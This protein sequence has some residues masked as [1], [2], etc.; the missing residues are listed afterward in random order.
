MKLAIVARGPRLDS[1]VE[2]RF[3][4][5]RYL[6]VFDTDTDQS[7]P[8]DMR[9]S[10]GVEFGALITGCIGEEA[11]HSFRV[12]DVI[13]YEGASG[14]VSDAIDACVSGRLACAVEV[15]ATVGGTKRPQ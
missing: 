14:T 3:E 5:A 11:W 1:D 10:C 8:Y 4:D 12:G 9:A 2:P 15:A 6:I 13:V 7:I